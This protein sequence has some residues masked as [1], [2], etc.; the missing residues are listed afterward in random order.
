MVGLLVVI[1]FIVVNVVGH[2]LLGLYDEG[3]LKAWW[4]TDRPPS[5]YR[6]G[7]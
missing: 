6:K 2:V 4:T 3:S 5:R 7:L 1:G